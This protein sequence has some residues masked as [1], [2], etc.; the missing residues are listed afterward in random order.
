MNAQEAFDIIS[1]HLLTQNERSSEKSNFYSQQ[2]ESCLYRGPNGLKCAIGC[3]IPDE[4]YNL[5]MEGMTLRQLTKSYQDLKI[6]FEEIPENLLVA[7]QTVHDY[8]NPNQWRR[9]LK[10]I[11]KQHNL[12]FTKPSEQ[13]VILVINKLLRNLK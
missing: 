10:A 12:K 2:L 8:R 9:C 13:T 11:A 4:K 5:D 1:T 6:L 7:L 3:L